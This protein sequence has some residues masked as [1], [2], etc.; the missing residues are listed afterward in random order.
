M[1]PG[2]KVLL[3]FYYSPSK[4]AT[5]RALPGVFQLVGEP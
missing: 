3:P 2:C 5:G 4:D 1:R